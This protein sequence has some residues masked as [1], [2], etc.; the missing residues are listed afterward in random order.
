MLNLKPC[1]SVLTFFGF[2]SGA[3]DK[4]SKAKFIKFY[5][6]KIAISTD[7]C[8]F[9]VTNMSILLIQLILLNNLLN[10]YLQNI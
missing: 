6:V 2:R 3:T 10:M 7:H 1:V 4:K 5:N 9:I 8:I